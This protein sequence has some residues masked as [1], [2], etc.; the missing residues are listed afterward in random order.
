MADAMSASAHKSATEILRKHGRT[1]NFAR[2]FLT[3]VQGQRAARLYAFCRYVDDVADEACDRR[4][5]KAVLDQVKSQ[6]A[7]RLAPSPR[8]ADFLDLAR[9]T[10]I[11]FDAAVALIDGVASDLETVAFETISDLLR[12]AY[13]VA[14]TVGLMM[15]NVLDVDD[16]HAAPFAI[17]LGIAMQLTN[18]AR[19]IQED[20]ENGRRYVPAAWVGGASAIDIAHPDP[21]LMPGLQAAAE[22][23]IQLAEVYYQSAYN[24]FGFLPS[25]SRF[26][27]LIAARV[28]RQIGV[29]LHRRDF[30]V[31]RGRTIVSTAEKLTV[32]TAAAAA[33]LA[34]PRLHLRT[35]THDADL[36][37]T[38]QGLA[39]A[40]QV[41]L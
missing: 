20:A 9:E 14:G 11:D 25:R 5:A 31:W 36:H 6:L 34:Q 26:A 23:L 13:K 18:I 3:E 37:I 30:T 29:K 2:V 7:G 1:F 12:Y 35:Q 40:H 21:V 41:A 8:I 33:Y 24:G 19:D 16:P 17:D 4:H 32:A 22:R 15:C 39:G 38:L 10:N 28:Y 27:I